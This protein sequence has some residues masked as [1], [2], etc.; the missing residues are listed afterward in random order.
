MAFALPMGWSTTGAVLN[1]SMEESPQI[2]LLYFLI[3]LLL[4]A[5]LL[6]NQQAEL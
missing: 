4:N 3:N 6:C 2:L 1:H 5:V